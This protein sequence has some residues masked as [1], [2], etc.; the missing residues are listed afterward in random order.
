[1]S[2]AEAV[3]ASGTPLE[4]QVLGDLKALFTEKAAFTCSGGVDP[5]YDE[6]EHGRGLSL[7][8]LLGSGE[9]GEWCALEEDNWIE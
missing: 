5:S 1:M 2:I 8:F 6:Q 9:P 4:S 3:S 7:Y